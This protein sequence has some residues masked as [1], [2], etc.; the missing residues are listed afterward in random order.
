[1]NVGWQ[2]NYVTN[3]LN[4][5]AIYM[6]HC[7]A[8]ETSRYAHKTFQAETE[9]LLLLRPWSRCIVKTIVPQIWINSTG[10]HFIFVMLWVFYK[11]KVV[12]NHQSRSMYCCC[13]RH[14]L[15]AKA[16]WFALE[17]WSYAWRGCMKHL[18]RRNGLRTETRCWDILYRDRDTQVRDRNKTKTLSTLSEMRPRRDCSVSQDGLEIETT[19]LELHLSSINCIQIL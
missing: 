5:A 13:F 17:N 3:C 4:I 18:T 14:E 6:Y 12:V 19:S 8:Q 9:T 10:N 2:R 16:H 15:W 1:M 7:C 11:L